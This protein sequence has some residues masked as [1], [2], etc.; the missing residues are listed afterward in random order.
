[1]APLADRRRNAK[2]ILLFKLR[3]DDI[4]LTFDDF[5]IKLAARD[6][7]AASVIEEDGTITSYKLDPLNANK[8]PLQNSTIVSSIPLWNKLPGDILALSTT[9][10]FKSALA[11]RAP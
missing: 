3:T 7:K 9:D 6:T 5:D 4:A 2:L 10:S 8:S 11:S 1:M